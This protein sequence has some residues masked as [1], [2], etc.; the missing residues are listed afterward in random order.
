[1]IGEEKLIDA[2]YS[3]TTISVEKFKELEERGLAIAPKVVREV[4]RSEQELSLMGAI[5]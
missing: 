3:D 4:A 2:A 1:L 5:Y